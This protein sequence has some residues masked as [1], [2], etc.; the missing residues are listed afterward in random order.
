MAQQQDPGKQ[1]R[2]DERQTVGT[3]IIAA[4]AIVYN[5]KLSTPIDQ[6]SNG[7]PL[8]PVEAEKVPIT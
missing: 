8:S 5:N 4:T 6:I 2:V 7:I 1:Q 3:A